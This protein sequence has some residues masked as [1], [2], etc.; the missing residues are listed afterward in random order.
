M[1]ILICEGNI[2]NAKSYPYFEQLYV[3]LKNHE[4]KKIEGILKE[5]EII[6]L[7]NWSSVW[8]SV[9]SF[10]QHLAA[11]HKLKKGIVIWGTSHPE[12][13]G[14]PTN[15]NLLGDRK[16]LRPNPFLWWKDEV[17]NPDAFVAPEEI[18]RAIDN[19]L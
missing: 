15:I 17:N 14:Y 5:Q 18:I 11:Y 1:K 13:F 19:L 2:K 3:L 7:I 8:I 6:D 16:Y 10:V 9:D 4:I 12:I